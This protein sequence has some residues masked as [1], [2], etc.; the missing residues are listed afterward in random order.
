MYRRVRRLKKNK[1]SI[2][3]AKR[4]LGRGRGR[5]Y[6]RTGM[7]AM[8]DRATVVEVQ[9]NQVVPEGGQFINHTLNDFPRALAVS[10]SYRF[11]RCKKV[12]VE[13][14]PYANVFGPGQAFPE[15]YTQ[16]DRTQG[17]QFGPAVPQPVP[18]KGIMMSR[19]VL[20][21]K[22]TSV[23][24]RSYSPSVLRQENFI[25]NVLG[26]NLQS[27]ASI[28]S[29]PVLYK[30]YATQAYFSP[31]GST[32]AFATDGTWGPQLLRYYGMAFCVDQP[33]A[34]P[35]AVLGTIKIKV[36]WEFKEPLVPTE[37]T[38]PS[39]AEEVANTIH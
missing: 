26:G 20:P 17:T 29:T 18:T 37:P 16:V 23:I 27:I 3:G 1:R 34:E 24:K 36:H 4:R 31:P 10:K 33:L 25:Q 7:N 12:E 28:T 21:V 38:P 13:F 2:R 9:E 22:W 5:R 39:S 14:I 6:A 8:K 15:L 30:W 32:G 11:Y 19:G 35:S